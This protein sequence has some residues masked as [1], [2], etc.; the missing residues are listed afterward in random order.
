MTKEVLPK[1]KETDDSEDCRQ[2]DP[3]GRALVEL[4]VLADVVEKGLAIVCDP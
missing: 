3:N 2:D 1:S 4:P